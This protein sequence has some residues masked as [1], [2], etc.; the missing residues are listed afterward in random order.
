VDISDT[1]K[2]KPGPLASI[3][4]PG[5]R[6]REGCSGIIPKHHYGEHGELEVFCRLFTRLATNAT[7]NEIMSCGEG[8]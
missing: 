3:R 2:V 1:L 6:K 7:K 4:R 5:G 8:K